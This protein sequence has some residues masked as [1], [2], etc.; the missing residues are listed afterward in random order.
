MTF[1]IRRGAIVKCSKDSRENEKFKMADTKKQKC[2]YPCM[3]TSHEEQFGV[4]S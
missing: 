4:K 1:N 2:T 3:Y